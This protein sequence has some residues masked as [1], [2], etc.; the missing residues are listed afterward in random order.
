MVLIRRVL[1]DVLDTKFRRVE[2]CI[3]TS[4]SVRFKVQGLLPGLLHLYPAKDTRRFTGLRTVFVSS[5]DVSRK[6]FS[7][8][9]LTDK[10]SLY[11]IRNSADLF[12]CDHGESATAAAT[13][14]WDICF[15]SFGLYITST[16]LYIR[17]EWVLQCASR[18]G[19]YSTR[20]C[21]A[22]WTISSRSACGG[23]LANGIIMEVYWGRKWSKCRNQFGTV[24]ET[25]NRKC[26]G[27][28][29]PRNACLYVT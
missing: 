20:A 16:G 7:F 21:L 5:I 18:W 11:F 4:T 27:L 14:G 15:H 6:H 19:G 1:T 23:F 12:L 28:L 13:S 17:Q 22:V 25:D 26:R 29:Q 24:Q 9:S 8:V 10:T 3:S 2:I